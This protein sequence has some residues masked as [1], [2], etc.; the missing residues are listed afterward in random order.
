MDIFGEILFWSIFSTSALFVI[1]PSFCSS[2]FFKWLDRVIEKSE[3][4]ATSDW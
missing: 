4:D 1:F 2:L 3:G